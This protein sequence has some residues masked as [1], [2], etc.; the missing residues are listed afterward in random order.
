[1]CY[2]T[3]DSPTKCYKSFDIQLEINTSCTT[4]CCVLKLLGP[5]WC[6]NIQRIPSAFTCHLR[7]PTRNQ[8]LS[9][10]YLCL[11]LPPIVPNGSVSVQDGLS[12]LITL[13]PLEVPPLSLP[14]WLLHIFVLTLAN[15]ILGMATRWRIFFLAQFDRPIWL[16]C[17]AFPIL[18]STQKNMQ[19]VTGKTNFLLGDWLWGK[20]NANLMEL[21]VKLWQRVFFLCLLKYLSVCMT[22]IMW[23]ETEALLYAFF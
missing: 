11:H 16:I 1:M 21:N 7:P 6:L 15:A 3:S 5:R 9:F 18:I 14:W 17:A 10:S 8:N 19:H 4:A 20:D 23:S 22:C 2:S 13:T 12:E